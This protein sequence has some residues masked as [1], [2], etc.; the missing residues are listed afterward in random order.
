MVKIALFLFMILNLFS[1]SYAKYEKLAYDF[2]FKSIDGKII[3]LEDF[4]DKVIVVVNVASRCGYTPQYNGLQFLHEK[5]ADDLIVIGVPSNDFRQEPG[6]N[7]EIKE[8]CETNFDI[9]FLITEKTNIIGN[10][11]HPF[12]KWARENHGVGAIPKW[13]FHKIIVGQN[14]KVK[15]TFS[16]LTKPESKKF[17]KAIEFEI[18][19]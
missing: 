1:T 3:K 14:G 8:F 2:S 7:N 11:A 12:F 19:S 4:K 6:T 10:K 15:K 13:N 17:I 16:S 9:T 5:F 18:K